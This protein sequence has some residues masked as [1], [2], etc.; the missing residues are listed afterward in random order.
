MKTENAKSKLKAESSKLKGEPKTGLATEIREM[1]K[2]SRYPI[3]YSGVYERTGARPGAERQR[4][5][6]AV[7]EFIRRG[8]IVKTE[9]GRL[10]YNHARRCGA[11]EGLKKERV[12]KAMYISNLFTYKDITTLVDD[13]DKNYVEEIV[14]AL[15]KKGVITALGKHTTPGV[16]GFVHMYKVADRVKFR[17][18][19]MG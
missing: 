17:M 12:L 19:E 9:S 16:R 14:R 11:R 7:K 13:I 5:L 8:E 2:T 4:V 15:I 6:H 3:T 1:F 10:R 18:E